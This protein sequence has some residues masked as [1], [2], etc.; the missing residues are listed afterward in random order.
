MTRV[1]YELAG[2]D[3]RRFSPFCWRARFALAHKGLDVRTEPVR[4]TDKDKIAFS[5]QKLVPVLVDDNRV[6]PDSW[7]IA[8]HLEDAYPE[9]PS[10]FGGGAARP[11]T[12]FIADWVAG[13]VQ[14]AL[15]FCVAYDIWDH[16]DPADRA[17]FRTSRETRLGRSLEEIRAERPRH[18]ETLDRTLVPLRA[19][20]AAQPWVAGEQPAY[21]DYVVFAAFQWVRC[22]SDFRFLAEDDPIRGWRDRVAALFD[23]MA[24]S[25]PHYR[26]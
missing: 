9:A 6:V 24:D 17:Y 1:L 5:N 14:P 15:F 7:A 19:V 23:G 3:D 20:L 10:L 25:V 18:A 8:N 12:R 26:T 4:F 11:L 21:A 13:T 2:R 22:I 16:A